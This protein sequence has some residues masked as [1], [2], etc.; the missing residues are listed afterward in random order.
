MGDK[1]LLERE[2]EEGYEERKNF[3]PLLARRSTT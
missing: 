2:K 1:F 3:L